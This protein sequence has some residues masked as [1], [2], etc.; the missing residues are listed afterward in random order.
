MS[1]KEVAYPSSFDQLKLDANNKHGYAIWLSDQRC[2]VIKITFSV[3]SRFN[4]EES[5]EIL[6]SM[7]DMEVKDFLQGTFLDLFVS[8]MQV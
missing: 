4:V 6:N 2:R 7:P 8:S 3:S 1:N 5:F